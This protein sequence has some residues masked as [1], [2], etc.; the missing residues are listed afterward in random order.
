MTDVLVVDDDPRVAQINAAHVRRP[1]LRRPLG[2]RGLPDLPKGHSP[3]TEE[4]VRQVLLA[5]DGAAFSHRRFTPH[6]RRSAP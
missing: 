4:L 1:H 5:A 6:R 2:G 3:T